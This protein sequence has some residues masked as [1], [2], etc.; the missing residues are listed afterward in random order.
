M[1]KTY[2]SAC[3]GKYDNKFPF[4]ST[5]ENRRGWEAY[6]AEAKRLY[7]AFKNDLAHEYGLAKHPKFEKAFEIAWEQGHGSG[8]SDVAIYFDEL[9]ELIK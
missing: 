7:D 6:Q 3:A 8:Y 5:L 4:F 2:D 9:A 1:S